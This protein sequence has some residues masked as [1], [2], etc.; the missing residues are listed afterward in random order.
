MQNWIDRAPGYLDNVLFTVGD[1]QVTLGRALTGLALFIATFIVAR[2]IGRA[3]NRAL[4]R[5]G[6]G[7]E[8]SP[9]VYA[10][11]ARLTVLLLGTLA[12]LSVAGLDLSALFAAGGLVAVGAGFA[13]RNVVENFISGIILRV[14]R[15]LKRGDIIGLD[16]GRMVR[17]KDVGIRATIAR[18]RDD[19]DI[20]I[21]NSLLVQTNVVNYTFDDRLYRLHVGVGVTYS[22]DMD[23][24]RAVL[25]ETAREI[26]FR[27]KK[28]RPRIL[29]TGF[30]SS[31][32]DW[33]V[34]IWTEDP[35]ASRQHSSALHEAIWRS[36]AKAGIVIAFPQLDVH[37]DPPKDS[38]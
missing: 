2:L 34:S 5:R 1:S 17:I 25:E 11:T 28:R 12:S 7:E 23:Q 24:V 33:D 16:D 4:Q 3:I 31:S 38:G 21:P 20:V 22:S 36:L 26:P 18:D 29:M 9:Q 32:V 6:L 30:G 19:Q 35:W 15:S 14:E 8:D 13:M 37:F 10:R 27:T